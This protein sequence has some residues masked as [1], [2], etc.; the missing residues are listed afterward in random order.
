MINF[1]K[2]KPVL[3]LIAAAVLCI[4]VILTVRITSRDPGIPV[5]YEF[6]EQ[7]GMVR[8]KVK[9]NYE[10]TLLQLNYGRV[11]FPDYDSNTK[12]LSFSIYELDY[13]QNEF[14][15]FHCSR[16]DKEKEGDAVTYEVIRGTKE[17]TIIRYRFGFQE[18]TQIYSY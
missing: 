3:K 17:V 1:W 18:D 13:G 9:P 11:K 12:N 14:I 7:S 15:S 2:R 5:V 10:L 4:L 8:F 16:T 6:D